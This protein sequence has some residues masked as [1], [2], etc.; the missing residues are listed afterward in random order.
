MGNG[1]SSSASLT[2]ASALGLAG[3]FGQALC[4]REAALA[5]RWAEHVYAGVPCGPL[6]P[7]VVTA[8]VEGCALLIDFQSGETEPVP[9]PKDAAVAVCETGTPR[10]LARTGYSDRR[11]ETEEAAKIL[12]L[13]HLRRATPELIESAKSRMGETL[14]RRALHVV[15]EN[16]RVEQTVQTVKTG[17][18]QR[19]RRIFSASH[20]SLR[21][22]FEASCIEL[23][24]MVEICLRYK[25]CWGARMT[26]GGFG[27]AVVA[28]VDRDM[29]QEFVGHVNGEYARLI[30][31]R[32]ARLTFTGAAGGAYARPV[33]TFGPNDLRNF[34]TDHLKTADRRGTSAKGGNSQSKRGMG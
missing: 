24:T 14:A 7:T 32:Q 25:G 8:A 18:I 23:D 6:D 33:S 15:W 10:D 22:L 27:G 2:V 9:W 1:L 5:A 28:L 29:T 11:R 12:G 3:L 20:D 26:G 31:G 16:R 21:N 13:P 34:S 19:L 30:P 17:D 4:P